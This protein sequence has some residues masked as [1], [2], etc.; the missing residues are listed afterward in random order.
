METVIE[1]SKRLLG[2]KQV[3]RGVDTMIKSLIVEATFS[4]GLKTVNSK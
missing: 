4:T 3:Q 2:R 1:K